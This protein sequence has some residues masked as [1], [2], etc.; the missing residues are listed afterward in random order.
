MDFLTDP[1]F[2][3]RLQFALTTAFHITFPTLTIGLGVY[4]VVV[5][6]LW[7]RTGDLVYFRQFR[8]WSRLFA[9]NFAV[10]VVSGIPLEFQFGANWGPFSASVGNFFGQVLGFEGT[11]AFMLESAFL[12]I[13]LFGWKRVGPK[14]HFAATILVAFAASL[15]A[16]W[17]LVAN[18][19]MQTPA[20][21]HMANGF[22]VVD[23]Y[24]AAI[25]SPDL[26]L[27]FS[28]MY[29]ACLEL[30]LFVIGAVSG[31][32]I[33]LGRHTEFY[34]KSFKIAAVAAIVVAPLQAFIGDA[35]GQEIGRLQPA[36][37]AAI[38]AHWDT[39]K[40][41]TGAPWNMLAWP[42]PENERNFF[43]IEI[44]YA[45]SLL[46]T[47]KPT[48]IVPGLKDF[49]KQDRP[50]IVLPFYSFRLMVG[51]G[52]MMVAVMLW[53][54]WEWRKGG[55]TPET[56]PRRKWLFE[57]WG[58]MA[59]GAYVAVLMGWITREVGR[60][61]WLAYG[62]IRRAE[63]HSDLVAAEVWTSLSGF[64]IAYAILFTLFL[65]FMA[66]LL[67][68]GPNMNELP[69]PGHVQGETF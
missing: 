61:P 37:V 48:G 66:K 3:S 69:P 42:D 28:H 7:L 43:Q 50:P 8:F 14:M 51:I 36:K 12:Y 6:W 64:L 5:E 27:A 11:M 62:L 30:T 49:P 46:I 33:L 34:L 55:L 56:A 21:G 29:I 41:G 13:M 35:N 44:P 19:W 68:R 23:N 15:S 22:F 25:F 54:L 31:A 57:A 38:E 59:A 9:V 4:L 58:L 40:P 17:I 67:R 26:P 65:F 47:H 45:L 53:T 20:G 1:V 10:G 39:N 63:G 24:L 18:S 16:F 52:F 32:N 2:L 60:Q